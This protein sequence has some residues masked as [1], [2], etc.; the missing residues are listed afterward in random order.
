MVKQMVT[1]EQANE[2]FKQLTFN[3]GGQ[4]GVPPQPE[5]A[6]VPEPETPEAEQPAGDA[7]PQV[8]AGTA[9]E[10]Q[11]PEEVPAPTQQDVDDL[12]KRF[13]ERADATQQ[14]FQQNQQILNDRNLRKS[15]S[16]DRL[17]NALM[18][19]RTEGGIAESEVDRIIRE[20]QGTM[21]PASASFV[22]PEPAPVAVPLVATQEEQAIV[23]NNFLNEKGMTDNEATEFG[24]WI[25]SD[26][27]TALTAGEQDVARQSIDGFLRIA[28]GRWQ[29]VV[30]ENKRSD[31]VDAVR[32]VQRTQRA[33]AKA[34][35]PATT[36]PKTQP[37]APAQKDLKDLTPDDVSKLVRLSITQY[38]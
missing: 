36:A 38:Q 5:S 29:G 9:A 3:S 1:E 33:A 20:A 37:A 2:A 7:V 27:Q 6:P 12:E 18:A 11:V 8:E 26:G 28:H 16:H 19:T 31:A 14:R 22:A 30:K 32:T 23:T 17:L 24:N 13:Q 15:T 25:T 4:D 34:A 21:N 35:S 10:V